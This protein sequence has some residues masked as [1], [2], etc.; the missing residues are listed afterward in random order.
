ML[1][2]D[3][4]NEF[5]IMCD[6]SDYAMGVVLGKRTEKIFMAIYYASKTINEA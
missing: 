6:V 5:E 2:L 4:N 1:T 3:Y